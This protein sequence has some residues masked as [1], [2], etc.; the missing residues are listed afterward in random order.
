M[1][2]VLN[3]YNV[4]KIISILDVFVDLFELKSKIFGSIMSY[5]RRYLIDTLLTFFKNKSNRK[6]KQKLCL[7]NKA[8]GAIKFFFLCQFGF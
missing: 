3:F 1:K 2:T 4:R 8:I 6:I 5:L 7:L